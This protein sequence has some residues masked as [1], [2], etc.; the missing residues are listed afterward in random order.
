MAPGEQQREHNDEHAQQNEPGLALLATVI[1]PE[2]VDD[3]V[4][5]RNVTRA[6]VELVGVVNVRVNG[7]KLRDEAGHGL[8]V[9]AGVRQRPEDSV[10]QVIDVVRAELALD[11]GSLD[12]PAAVLAHDVE[13]QHAVVFRFAADAPGAE[14]QV[15]VLLAVIALGQVV[16]GDDDD[17]R[18]GAI[19]LE[20]AV[21]VED[22]LPCAFREGAG[23]VVDV[24]VVPRAGVGYVRGEDR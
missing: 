8:I 10:E 5:R 3:S 11:A 24:E 14:E 9:L 13:Q 20:R 4:G 17:L 1:I 6:T 12:E 19:L 7:D 15:R 23:L 21:D 2:F 16:D 18:A 22:E